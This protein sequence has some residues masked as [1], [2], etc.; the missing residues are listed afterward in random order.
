MVLSTSR[1]YLTA[2]IGNKDVLVLSNRVLLIIGTM[3]RNID[4]DPSFLLSVLKP[5]LTIDDTEVLQ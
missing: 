1:L 4:R 3:G 5:L 2:S